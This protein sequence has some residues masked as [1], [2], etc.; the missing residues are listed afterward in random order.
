MGELFSGAQ[1]AG[2]FDEAWEGS[3]EAG[4]LEA[5]A[6]DAALLATMRTNVTAIKALVV[7]AVGRRVSAR[8]RLREP[9][10]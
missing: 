2:E 6:S 7:P 3:A 9:T 4:V 8:E 5:E 10:W 1:Q